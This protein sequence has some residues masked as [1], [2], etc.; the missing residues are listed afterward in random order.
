[1]LLFSSIG[2]KSQCPIYGD[3]PLHKFQM[4][5]SLKNRNFKGKNYSP[6]SLQTILTYKGDDSKIYNSNQYVSLKGYVTLVKYGDAETCNCH[7]KDKNDLDIHIEIALTPNTTGKN[8]M[9]VEIN[10]YTRKDHPEFSLDNIK[11][12]IGKQVTVEGWLF[13]DE[14]HKQNAITS[15]PN[16]TNL[17]RY[18]TLEV[19]PVMNIY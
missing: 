12:L 14:E 15:N 4:L 19:H 13:Y 7:S 3:K 10:R 2:V 8:A 17:W 5:D 1:M 6:L 9:I 18:T 16:G 11:K